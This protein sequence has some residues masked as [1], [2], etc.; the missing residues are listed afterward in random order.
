[1]QLS[2]PSH[3]LSSLTKEYILQFN[4][5][6]MTIKIETLSFLNSIFL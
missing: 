2:T 1:M 3:I 6:S 5:V 4:F